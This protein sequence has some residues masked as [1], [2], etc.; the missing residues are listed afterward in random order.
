MLELISSGL[1]SLWLETA[2][3]EAS[4]SRSPLPPPDAWGV[5]VPQ[6]DLEV[7]RTIDAYLKALEGAGMQ[8]QDQGLWLQADIT[9]LGS[10]QGMEVRRAASIT[11]LATTLAVLDALS[12]DWAIETTVLVRG[13]VED[14]TLYGQLIVSGDRDPF[15]V[16]EEALE[17]GNALQEAGI[18]RVVGEIVVEGDVML[19]GEDDPETVATILR[20]T[21]SPENWTPEIES[22]YLRMAKGTPRPKIPVRRDRRRGKSN[23]LGDPEPVIVHRSLSAIGLLKHM[24][25]YSDNIL[26][27]ELA[28]RV[29]TPEAI[30]ARVAQLARVPVIEIQLADGSGL[31]RNNQISPRAACAILAAIQRH[32]WPH[33]L[34]VGDVLPIF[35]LDG[36]TMDDRSMPIDTTAKT[37][38][39]WDTSALAGVFPTRDRGLVWFAIFNEGEDYTLNFR[40]QQDT[41]LRA[42]EQYWG[43]TDSR[44]DAIAP[45]LNNETEARLGAPGR[46]RIVRSW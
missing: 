37:G 1:L 22:A 17:L 39:L 34:T 29:G 16:Y 7:N 25:V 2:G 21:W 11:K 33:G 19:E 32:L 14:G 12:V 42:L 35:G 20:R 31:D 46:N 6:T 38:T 44:L 30:A 40:E 23:R 36:G 9:G 8:R 26:A 10:H 28:D 5:A 4:A 24:N 27:Q 3:I 45:R 15:F 43:K 18:D 41:L 13:E